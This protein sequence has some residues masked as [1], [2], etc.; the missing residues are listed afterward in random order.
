MN[1]L[2][3]LSDF[4]KLMGCSQELM[5]MCL[6]HEDVLSISGFFQGHQ[7]KALSFTLIQA[8]SLSLVGFYMVFS[9]VAF[10]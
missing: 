6:A 10:L 1:L 5:G 3:F 7:C 2:W 8:Q 9:V 4:V